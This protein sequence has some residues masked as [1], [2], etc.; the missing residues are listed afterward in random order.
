MEFKILFK[1][2]YYSI[3]IDSNYKIK[4][5]PITIKD[6][7]Q[8]IAEYSNDYD[9][10]FKYIF[11]CICGEIISEEIPLKNFNCKG[12]HLKISNKDNNLFLLTQIKK[13]KKLI[14]QKINILEKIKQATNGNTKIIIPQNQFSSNNEINNNIRIRRNAIINNIVEFNQQIMNLLGNN[15]MIPNYDI[16]LFNNIQEMGFNPD[17]IRI[18]LR[19]TSNSFNDAVEML[20]YSENDFWEQNAFLSQE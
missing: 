1:Q 3:T 17:H 14:P 18:S 7:I 20:I 15:V 12:I 16:N 10:S 5:N 6:L 13:I 8:I 19:L 11:Q 4:N 9:P 2:Y